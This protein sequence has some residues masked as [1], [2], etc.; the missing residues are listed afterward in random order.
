MTVLAH[1]IAAAAMTIVAGDEY[2][3]AHAKAVADRV[4][5]VILVHTS[6]CGPCKRL[7]REL[8]GDPHKQYVL[9]LAD[10]S[11]QVGREVYTGQGVPQLTAYWRD[12]ESRWHNHTWIGFRTAE[13]FRDELKAAID[14]E[15]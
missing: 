6:T 8:K 11:D 9:H 3:E 4:P 7:I 14:K 2:S 10:A 15:R 12:S 1:V 13:K 5:L